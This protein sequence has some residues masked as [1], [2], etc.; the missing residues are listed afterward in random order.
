M[1]VTSTAP[2]QFGI[3]VKTVV[4][5]IIIAGTNHNANVCDGTLIGTVSTEI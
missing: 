4:G 3:L 1:P 5:T 2:S